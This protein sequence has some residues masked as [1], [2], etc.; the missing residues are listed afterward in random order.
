MVFYH[1]DRPCRQDRPIT[2]K[3]ESRGISWSLIES[4]RI[5]WNLIL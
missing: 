2:I 4:R 1:Q 5:S 3:V